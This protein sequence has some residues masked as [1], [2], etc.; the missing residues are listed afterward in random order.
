LRVFD[1]VPA[2]TA[3]PKVGKLRVLAKRYPTDTTLRLSLLNLGGAYREQWVAAD[4]LLLG[5]MSQAD[6]VYPF[7]LTKALDAILAR[8]LPTVPTGVLEPEAEAALARLAPPSPLP[9]PEPGW[10]YPFER[11]ALRLLAG[12]PAA[13]L[14]RLEGLGDV[15]SV[16]R[17]QWRCVLAHQGVDAGDRWLEEHGV[18]ALPDPDLAFLI[19]DRLYAMGL[20]RTALEFVRGVCPALEGEDRQDCEALLETLGG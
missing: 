10:W 7:E 2:L 8:K 9:E 14:E 13:C 16:A 1:G 11:A 17:L 5:A 3:P 6:D 15:P 4:G 12:E 20:S 18:P 19:A